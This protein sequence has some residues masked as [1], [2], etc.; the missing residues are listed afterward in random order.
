MRVLITGASGLLGRY[1][2]S[3]RP[4]SVTV[5]AW[6]SKEEPPAVGVPLTA[7]NLEEVRTL[8]GAYR[9][10]RPAAV[11]HLAA[12]SNVGDCAREPVRA[13]RINTEATATLAALA[14]S[15]G[16]PMLFASTDLVFDGT[17]PPYGE[18]APVNPLSV[19]GRT[20]AEAEPAVLEAGG[21]V[22]RFPL[23]FGPGRE[24]RTSFFD[25]M[26]NAVDRGA[27]LPLFD[28]EYR[29]PLDLASAASLLWALIEKPHPGIVHAG[30]PERMSRYEMGTRLAAYL[31]VSSSHLQKVPRSAVPGLEP[32]PA[33]TSMDSTL[34]ARILPSLP[35][36]TYE[37][38][39]ADLLESG[40]SI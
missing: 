25:T 6:S 16:I 37:E 12:W 28:D 39:L 30:G 34:L 20:K 1:V 13:R 5:L 31:G 21:T 18:D 27:P 36:P 19:Y 26:L 14:R 7:V 8:E 4:A 35:S 17:Q 32:R 40:E 24:G 22:V 23:L 2:L 29:T 11:V 15:D 3:A 10:S 38:A 9:M 33:D